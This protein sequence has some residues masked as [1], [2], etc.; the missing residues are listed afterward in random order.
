MIWVIIQVTKKLAVYF[1]PRGESCGHR[2]KLTDYLGLVCFF[3][4]VK[5]DVREGA[6]C[7]EHFVRI[8]C[9]GI[10][11]QYQ[12]RISMPASAGNPRKI[13]RTLKDLSMNQLWGGC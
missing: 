11:E 7:L 5:A 4:N 3:A 1:L 2:I 12:I 10:L 13:L 8:F 9:K 6:R